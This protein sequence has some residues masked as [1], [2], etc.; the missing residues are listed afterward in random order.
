MSVMM[1]AA[2]CGSKVEIKAEGNDEQAALD[3]IKALI[4]D[5]FGEGE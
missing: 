5:R 1:L 3:A 4:D 2:S